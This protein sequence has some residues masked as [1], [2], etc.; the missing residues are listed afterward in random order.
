M[1]YPV[2][3]MTHTGTDISTVSIEVVGADSDRTYLL[4][5]NQGTGSVWIRWDGGVA[6]ADK[7]ADK[8]FPGQSMEPRP[9]MTASAVTAISLTG[10]VVHVVAGA[11]PAPILFEDVIVTAGDTV[12]VTAGDIVQVAA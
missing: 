3:T 4:V 6:V 1:S 10:S 7:T 11:P 5:Q 9:N 12:I 8:L 2:T